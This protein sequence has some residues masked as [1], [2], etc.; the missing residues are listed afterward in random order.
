VLY[1]ADVDMLF[2]REESTWRPR[3]F[4]AVWKLYSSI[5]HTH[6]KHK[7]PMTP[8]YGAYTDIAL[9]VEEVLEKGLNVSFTI[10]PTEPFQLVKLSHFTPA[11]GDNNGMLPSSLSAMGDE[12]YLV[13]EKVVSKFS[14][15]STSEKKYFQALHRAFKSNSARGLK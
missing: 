7:N 6:Y 12:D 8:V 2:L 3:R 13:S 11:Q 9:V 10:P 14:N 1:V 15:S 4:T 5:L